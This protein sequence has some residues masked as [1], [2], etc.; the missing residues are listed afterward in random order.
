MSSTSSHA[1]M[2]AMSTRAGRS[3]EH[4]VL[5]VDGRRARV[6]GVL[7]EGAELRLEDEQVGL[8]R[9]GYLVSSE[10]SVVITVG[11]DHSRW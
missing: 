9:G 11:G 1:V 4:E 6:D 8:D 3:P 7:A 2:H 5:V 10:K